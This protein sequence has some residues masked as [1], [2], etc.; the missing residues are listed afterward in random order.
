ME[1]NPFQVCTRCRDRI[2]VFEPLWVELADGTISPSSCLNLGQHLR[3]EERR[4]A[5]FWHAACLAPDA[6]PTAAGP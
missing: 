1:D 3:N 6:I 4:L 5:R 2:G